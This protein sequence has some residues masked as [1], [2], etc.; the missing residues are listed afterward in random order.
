M[1]EMTGSFWRP[2]YTERVGI[3]AGV[4]GGAMDLTA[5]DA[6]RVAEDLASTVA[7]ELCHA[8]GVRHHGNTD[9]RWVEFVRHTRPSGEVVILERR[10]RMD[11]RT[12]QF[13]PVATGGIV[14]GNEVRV[15]SEAGGEVLPTSA[16]FDTPT[17]VYV[18]SAGG[19]HSGSTDCVMRYNNAQWYV[20]ADRPRD[21]VCFQ[22]MNPIGMDLCASPAAE[23]VFKIRFGDATKGDCRHRFAVRDD[24]PDVKK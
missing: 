1:A 16:F 19:E 23:G 15:I 13:V 4:V 2:K 11:G 18:A 14:V 20:P 5:G 7:H 9:L 22:E 21:R 3:S 24:A 6:G 12:G 17:F 10:V 8:C